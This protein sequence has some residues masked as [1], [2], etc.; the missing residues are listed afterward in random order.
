MAFEY[1]EAAYVLELLPG[2]KLPDIAIQMLEAASTASLY[3]NSPDCRHPRGVMRG[4]CSRPPWRA[5]A[6]LR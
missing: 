1:E 6:P 3:A 5:S 4:P 2:E